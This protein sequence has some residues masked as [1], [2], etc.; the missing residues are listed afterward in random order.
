[1]KAYHIT[2]R[3]LVQGVGFRPFIYNLAN[4]FSICG[5]VLNKGS[6]VFIHAEGENVELF[7]RAVLKEKPA[8]SYVYEMVT[9]EADLRGINGFSIQD[10]M[11]NHASKS[12]ISPDM[13]MCNQCRKEIKDKENRRLNYSFTT[14]TDCGPRFSII[15][16]T[17]F[18]RVN[19]SMSQYEMCDQCKAE[20]RVPFD[21]RHHSQTNSCQNCGPLIK[22]Y[23]HT[24][25]MG[26]GDAAVREAADYLGKGR[27]AAIKGIGGY[28]LA[29]NAKDEQ[30]IAALRKKKNRES[31]P[32]A[33]MFRDMDTL[34]YYCET[35]DPSR[36]ILM[37]LASP[38]VLLKKKHE[39]AE[40]IAAGQ[41]KWG[42][43][44]PYTP[45]HQI[46]FDLSGLEAMVMT[47]ANISSE[48]I[49]FHDETDNLLSIADIVLTHDRTIENPCDDS[50]VSVFRGE[51]YFFRRARGY[52]PTP[53]NFGEKQNTVL[54]CGGENNSTFCL[55]N[56][57]SSYVSQYL[58]DLK[59]AGCMLN[60]E[61][62]ISKFTGMLQI[63]PDLAAYDMH[64]EYN[65]SKYANALGMKKVA[66]QHHHAHMASCMAENNITDQAIGVIWDGTGYGTDGTVWGGEFLVGGYS[67]FERKG[68]I[69]QV[70]QYGGERAVKEPWRMALSWL[71]EA[72][73]TEKALS[74]I[75]N[76]IAKSLIHTETIKTSSAGRL[77]DAVAAI[78]GICHIN[79]FDAQAPMALENL[80]AQRIG[81]GSAFDFS[82]RKEKDRN[83]LDF[84]A[85]IR[86]ILAC[87]E[88]NEELN[89]TSTR[90]H[91]TMA[92][93][94]AQMCDIIDKR[95]PIVLSGGV[96][97]NL[98]LLDMTVNELEKRNR[99]V[100]WHKRVP[101]ND[102]GLSLGQCFAAINQ[103][104]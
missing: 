89:I 53:I 43:M 11:V 74:V 100:F 44:L 102:G 12:Y 37:S 103:K 14:C 33:V 6:D 26:S 86:Q 4:S 67:G 96:F 22:A 19:T 32:L 59:S 75:G 85:M 3:G 40:P 70:N 45:L 9:E 87:K 97:Q 90:F 7:I 84:T 54:A 62:C 78:L 8:A 104:G 24:G 88:R 57:G 55:Y 83:V 42:A 98:I 36:T 79:A 80:A 93:A 35:D 5:Y 66:V 30:V 94:I 2:I 28:H 50:V 46:L 76:P 23:T 56:D 63:D 20:Y 52:V 47:S 95:L 41:S 49:I 82:I 92:C 71:V 64:P 39:I 77:F 61:E 13:A 21:R 60:F 25:V 58:G 1:M 18:D 51:P 10:S 65:S 101:A 38:I 69:M 16:K 17:L 48:P 68:H 73:G 81:N 99:K 27:I 15:Q 34:A 91:L 31:K 29:C 72:A